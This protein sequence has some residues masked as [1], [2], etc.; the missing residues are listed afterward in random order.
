MTTKKLREMMRILRRNCPP[1]MPVRVVRRPFKTTKV[2]K[3]KVIECGYAL[4]LK[5]SYRIV[6]NSSLTPT[7]QE[8]TLLH[9]YAHV[10]AFPRQSPSKV[11]EHD[12]EWGIAYA[13]V[14]RAYLKPLN[15]AGDPYAV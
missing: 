10:I 13:K 11:M 15:D 8:E 14:W 1:D 2:G 4:S 6:L 5:S 3:L 9:E 7:E 12:R